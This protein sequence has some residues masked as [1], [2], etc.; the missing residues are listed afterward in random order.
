MKRKG[1]IVIKI[2]AAVMLIAVLLFHFFSMQGRDSAPEN[3]PGILPEVTDGQKAKASQEEIQ[4]DGQIPLADL[5]AQ[6][7]AWE[8]RNGA[9][10]SLPVEI[11]KDLQRYVAE[12]ECARALAD[13]R[14]E[15]LIFTV[16]ELKEACP[17]YETLVEEYFETE[18]GDHRL[19]TD[20]IYC[21]EEADGQKCFLL[22][23]L[24]SY[25]YEDNKSYLSTMLLKEDGE[26]WQ[27]KS[28]AS[29]AWGGV[30]DYEIFVRKE[31]GKKSYYLLETFIGRDYMLE[32]SEISQSFHVP[33]GGWIIM[34][35][36]TGVKS[37]PVFQEAGSNIAVQIKEYVEENMRFLAWMQQNDMPIWG[38]EDEQTHDEMRE[39]AGSAEM[40]GGT[41]QLWLIDFDGSTVAFQMEEAQDGS[42]ALAAY[43]REGKDNGALLFSCRICFIQEVGVDKCTP[44]YWEA[45]GFNGLETEDT[46]DIWLRDEVQ[47]QVWKEQQQRNISSW[48]GENYYSEELFQ[49]LREEAQTCIFG[50]ENALLDEYR[51]DLSED[52][53]YFMKKAA[54][55][56]GKGFDFRGE[57]E[58]KWAYRWLGEDGIENFLSCINYHGGP[59]DSIQWW[60]TAETGLEEYSYVTETDAPSFLVCCQ[61]QV[62]CITQAAL[63]YRT[64]EVSISIMEIGNLENWRESCF[65][66]LRPSSVDPEDFACISLYE[67]E[68][69]SPGVK[70]YVQERCGEMVSAGVGWSFSLLSGM[71]EESG[72]TA[73]DIR[74]LNSLSNGDKDRY[75]NH[76]Y[77]AADVD[78]DGI[79]EY[80]FADGGSG[81]EVTFYEKENGSF[82]VVP[83]EELLPDRGATIGTNSEV[84]YIE[85]SFLQ[86]L[87]CERLEDTTYLF[88]MES[89]EYSPD[90][91]LRIRVVREGC[92]EDKAIYLL[93]VNMEEYCYYWDIMDIR[94]SSEGV[95]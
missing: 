91:I 72:L 73:E 44:V 76:H 56:W 22:F 29:G 58:C 25:G 78:N 27:I 92:V 15:E 4:E 79:A 36:K 33:I 5:T 18:Y 26:E 39:T 71:E 75:A 89:L 17:G 13:Y 86:E 16:E 87:W 11:L 12:A 31:E 63:E 21:L 67:E 57:G 1:F 83:F 34:P 85:T 60:K 6:C 38:D 55:T 94:L 7:E 28:N 47:E 69:L 61:G 74:M 3:G 77:F 14:Q 51:L 82:C 24:K 53:A 43:A 30:D 66:I 19:V 42:L 95:G 50:G 52:T 40:D 49:L 10:N 59:G 62:Y 54:E 8:G 70:D 80:G 81:L 20:K 93:K 65:F 37:E 23:Y 64:G 68:G 48:Q 90:Y 84:S 45:F 9:E 2:M 41:R 88:S 35:I 46:E 32:I